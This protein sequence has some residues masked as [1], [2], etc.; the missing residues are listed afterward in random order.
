MKWR[1]PGPH[2]R[3]GCETP[4]ER[5]FGGRRE[6]AGLFVP[7]MD[8]IDPTA[9][10]GMGDAVHRVPDD[11]V[12]CPHAGRLQRLDYEIGHS[13]AHGEISPLPCSSSIN[14]PRLRAELS[15][16]ICTERSLRH[17][18]QMGDHAVGRTG[19]RRGGRV[20]GRAAGMRRRREASNRWNRDRG[21][22]P[23]RVRLIKRSRLLELVTRVPMSAY[24]PLAAALRRDEIAFQ[25]LS[26]ST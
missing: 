1:L 19:M 16:W 12:A 11:P 26:L 24:T 22:P 5:R 4:G 10:D 13:F 2:S 3:A 9:V 23:R 7:H 8:P 20:S 25:C 14:R 17:I 21:A 15:R 6:G 18:P